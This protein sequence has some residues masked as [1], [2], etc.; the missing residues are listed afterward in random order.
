MVFGWKFS[1]S[2]FVPRDSVA[3]FLAQNDIQG[4]G[5]NIFPLLDNA[6]VQVGVLL[7]LISVKLNFAASQWIAPSPS[8]FSRNEFL[9]QKQGEDSFKT[10]VL[11]LSGGV[12]LIGLCIHP[13]G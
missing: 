9:C 4:Q 6:G 12:E 3:I 8:F 10:H 5:E 13:F 7:R 2:T 11:S 1:P